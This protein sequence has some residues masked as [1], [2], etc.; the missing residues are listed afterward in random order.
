[1]KDVRCKV[2]ANMEAYTVDRFL[3]M[4]E[5]TPGKRGPRSLAPVL[6]LDRRDIA[7]HER[8]CLTGERRE[9]VEADLE[10]LGASDES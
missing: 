2:C 5:G 8:V 3:V 7:R 9:K 6:G 1:V 4:P 10:R